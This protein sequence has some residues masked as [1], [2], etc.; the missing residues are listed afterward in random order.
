MNGFELFF[1]TPDKNKSCIYIFFENKNYFKTYEVIICFILLLNN[2]FINIFFFFL[3]KNKI[4]FSIKDPSFLSLNEPNFVFNFGK[5]TIYPL[6][7]C[8]L[9]SSLSINGNTVCKLITRHEESAII[10]IKTKQKTLKT[11]LIAGMY[12]QYKNIF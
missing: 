9:S 3:S 11:N 2:N 6:V 8:D 5:V 4:K 1:E 7:D 10:G 12:S